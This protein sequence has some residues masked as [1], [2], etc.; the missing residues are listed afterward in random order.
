MNEL[1]YFDTILDIIEK[2]HPYHADEEVDRI[3]SSR[4][5]IENL[6]RMRLVADYE[7]MLDE[8]AGLKIRCCKLLLRTYELAASKNEND[9]AY[10]KQV[11]RNLILMALT[12]Q[13]EELFHFFIT[14]SEIPMSD[15]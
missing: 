12:R 3:E 11:M 6:I 7:T 15:L 1:D 2:E 8:Q 14:F 9:L 10:G 4:L 5:M 13:L